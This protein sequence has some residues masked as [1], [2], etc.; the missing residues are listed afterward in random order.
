MCIYNF[1]CSV[2]T[3]LEKAQRRGKKG[4]ERGKG[5]ERKRGEKEKRGTE[6]LSLIDSPVG[7][8]ASNSI[9]CVYLKDTVDGLLVSQE[10]EILHLL[11]YSL[12]A[13]Y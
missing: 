2:H 7:K 8:T 5:R 3:P 10:R 12:G 1:L 6:K 9:F 4:R 13:V 11:D